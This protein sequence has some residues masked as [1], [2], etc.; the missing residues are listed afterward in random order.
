MKFKKEIFQILIAIIIVAGLFTSFSWIC[1]HY[2]NPSES[3]KDTLS[4]AVSF[5]GVLATIFAALIAVLLFNDWREQHNKNIESQ[6]CLKVFDYIQ[7]FEFEL[8]DIERFVVLYLT[9]QSKS[10]LYIKFDE[11]LE[12]LEVVADRTAIVLSDLGFIIPI[13]EFD[14]KFKPQFEIIIDQL[15]Q[16]IDTYDSMFRS[17]NSNESDSIF[18]EKYKSL[19]AELRARY[20]AIFVELN[21]YYK[22][23]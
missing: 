10:E 17:Y 5:M 21:E 12:R 1:I 20:R 14:I 18:I 19:T 4:I 7:E 8:I 6:L 9:H 16:Y 13:N 3:A 15:T 22:A 11:N 23:K 2:Q